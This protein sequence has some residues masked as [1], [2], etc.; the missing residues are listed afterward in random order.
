MVHHGTMNL[1]AIRDTPDAASDLVAVPMRMVADA[2][3]P[4]LG[5]LSDALGGMSLPD[6]LDID[7]G[8]VAGQAVEF[9]SDAAAVVVTQGGRSALRVVRFSRDNPKAALGALAVVVLLLGLLAA[10]RAK[11]NEKEL[12]AVS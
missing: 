11:S 10:K 8:D 3:L 2:N 4:D 5:D 9:A 7:V 6:A 12:D 1:S